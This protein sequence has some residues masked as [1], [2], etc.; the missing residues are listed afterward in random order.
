MKLLVLDSSG[1]V[2]SVAL[3]EDNRLIAEYTTGNKLTH[4]QTLLPMLNEVIKRTSF[5][6]ED[7]DAI[8]VAKGPG[9][10][11]GL[12]MNLPALS[13]GHGTDN[14]PIDSRKVN[15]AGIIE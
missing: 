3:I 12:R 9:S 7:I 1:L 8:A 6:M 14:D 13:S 4:S 10:F 5:D 11:T 2:A 15:C